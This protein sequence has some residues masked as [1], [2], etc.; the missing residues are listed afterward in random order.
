MRISIQG[1]IIMRG[2]GPITPGRTRSWFVGLLAVSLLAISAVPVLA[3][4]VPTDP[5]P[6]IACHPDYGTGMVT[7]YATTVET[8]ADA[9]DWWVSVEFTIA[10]EGALCE[11]SLATYELPSAEFTYPQS[12][13]D[14]DG[15][16][17]GPGTHTLT[18]A[19]PLD[20]ALPGCHSQ[21]DFV[22]GPSIAELTFDNRYDD[23]QIRARIVGDAAC[24]E[25]QVATPTPTPTPDE[26]EGGAT[27]SP[28]ATPRD[29][30]QGGNPTPTPGGGTLPD[31]SVPTSSSGPIAA[32]LSLLM[33]ASLSV[34]T[35]WRLVGARRRR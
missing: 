27:A 12:L 7:W 30:T 22:F 10:G 5:E 32:I 20:G 1:G 29:D 21:Y 18:A 9:T 19:L 34:A 2:S 16:T 8:P 24:P 35:T 13:H 11:L 15:G 3:I 33:L 17:F 23:R 14:A 25:E 26:S 28:T 6:D 4:R 31:T